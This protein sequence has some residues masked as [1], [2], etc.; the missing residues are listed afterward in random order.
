M[1]EKLLKKLAHG[2]AL[3][4][5]QTVFF[6][7][8]HKKSMWTLLRWQDNKSKDTTVPHI[9]AKKTTTKKQLNSQV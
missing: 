2:K 7:Y 6:F 9:F 4:C 8:P 3:F 5:Q 1:Q